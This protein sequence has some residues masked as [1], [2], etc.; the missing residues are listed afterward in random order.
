MDLAQLE[1][2][3]AVAEERSI[4]RAAARM[5]VSQP[6]LSERIRL[7]EREAGSPL[8]DRLPRGVVLTQAGEAFAKAARRMLQ[9]WH[10]ARRQVSDAAGSAGGT[11][12]IGAIPTI[13]PFVLPD[14][15]SRMS[16]DM[17]DVKINVVEDVTSSLLQMSEHGELDVALVSDHPDLHTLRSEK[18]GDEPL[19]L[20]VAR[21]HP[22]AKSKRVEWRQLADERLLSLHELHCLSNRVN[23]L[24][25]RRDVHTQVA[26]R[27]AQLFTLAGMVSKNLGVCVAPEMMSRQ[28]LAKDRVY[29]PIA[30]DTEGAA[31]RELRVVWNVL[32]YRTNAAR[33]FIEALRENIR[34]MFGAV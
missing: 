10:D 22:L 7:L 14:M 1:Y 17:P 34:E 15:L 23:E 12:A 13:A 21:K 27:G 4:S 8:F 24:C 18:L 6:A 26:M 11:L 20:M 3:L 9:E 29:L 28:D 30:R 32:R 25:A 16:V 33:A 2:F 31:T 5:F 19:C